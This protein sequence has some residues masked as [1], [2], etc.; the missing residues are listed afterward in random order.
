MKLPLIE[1]SLFYPSSTVV[2]VL[3][4]PL[5]LAQALGGSGGDGGGPVALA[6]RGQGQLVAGGGVVGQGHVGVNL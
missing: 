4:R 6:A 2:E 1:L 3:S 5:A